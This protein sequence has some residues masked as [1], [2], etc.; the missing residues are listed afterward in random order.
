MTDP[1][2]RRTTI[3]AK[4]VAL[5]QAGVI[6]ND[7]RPE[8]IVVDGKGVPR[9]IDFDVS[10]SGHVCLGPDQCG[11]LETFKKNLKLA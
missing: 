7:L 10:H 3:F 1:T 4:A 2:H 8:N 6:H 11:E 9:L 5:H